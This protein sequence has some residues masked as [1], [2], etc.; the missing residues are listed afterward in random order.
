MLKNVQ[1]KI[2][3]IIQ[4]L[5]FTHRFTDSFYSLCNETVIYK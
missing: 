1:T 3:N 2:F 4:M 5:I